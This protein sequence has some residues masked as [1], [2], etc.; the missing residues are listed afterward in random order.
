MEP[1]YTAADVERIIAQFRAVEYGQEM[2][3]APGVQARFVDAGHLCGS[4]CIALAVTEGRRTRTVVFSGDLGRQNAPMLRDP[5]R[6]PAADIVVLESTYGDREHKPLAATVAE[7]ESIVT[8]AVARRSKILVPTFAVGRA[9]LMLYLLAIM[10]CTAW[11]RPSP[12][13]STAMAIGRRESASA[14]STLYDEEFQACNGKP[15]AEDLDRQ[16]D[17]DPG[18]VTPIERLRRAPDLAG[19]GCTAGRILPPEAEPLARAPRSSSSVSGRG[20]SAG[21]SSRAPRP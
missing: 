18:P 8:A 5:E 17:R 1:L 3:V 21:N 7:F 11:C 12:S 6:F 13:T 2:P 4:A 15:L 20:R 16:G 10:F 19:S 14:M 9:Q